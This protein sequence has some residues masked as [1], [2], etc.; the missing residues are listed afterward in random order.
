[1]AHGISL[2]KEGD[3][4]S[5]SI[6]RVFGVRTVRLADETLLEVEIVGPVEVRSKTTRTISR[7]LLILPE[8]SEGFCWARIR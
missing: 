3:S 6:W 4:K 1:M 8:A 2:Y 5:N 7:Q